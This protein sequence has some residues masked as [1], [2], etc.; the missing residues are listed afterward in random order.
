MFEAIK[1][2]FQD[3]WYKITTA[4]RWLQIITNDSPGTDNMLDILIKKYE[5]ICEFI[6]DDKYI[7]T[8]QNMLDIAQLILKDLRMLK[9]IN[10]ST[11]PKDL[12]LEGSDNIEDYREKV[13]VRVFGRIGRNLE[14]YHF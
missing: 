3:K 4:M 13:Q 7:V 2:Y 9:S 5:D 1:Y 11:Y 14:K 10:D 6:S 12:D 8:D